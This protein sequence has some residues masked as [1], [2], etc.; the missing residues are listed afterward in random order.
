VKLCRRCDTP[1]IGV[2]TTERGLASFLVGQLAQ[3]RFEQALRFGI[4]R[5][6]RG[7]DE[8]LLPGIFVP[9]AILQQQRELI[10]PGGLPRLAVEGGLICRGR[11]CRFAQAIVELCPQMQLLRGR[12]NRGRTQERQRL[13]QEGSP[14]AQDR[15]RQLPQNCPETAP[16]LRRQKV[17]A[18][19][20]LYISSLWTRDDDLWNCRTVDRADDARWRRY[21]RTPG[22]TLAEGRQPRRGARQGGAG[23]ATRE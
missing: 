6:V 2:M 15:A 12:G 13:L 8:K 20:D 17:T 3:D 14:Q 22:D 18:A 11:R 4:I 19:P 10:A 16:K 21:L 5:L 7:Q 1:R 23:Q 9:S